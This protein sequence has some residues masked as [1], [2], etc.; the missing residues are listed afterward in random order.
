MAKVRDS[1]L[2]QI[3]GNGAVATPSVGDGRLIPYLLLDCQRRF[4]IHDLILNHQDQP[5]GDVMSSWA[6]ARFDSNSVFLHLD[7]KRPTP[8][9]FFIQFDLSKHAM[10]VDGLMQ[11]NVTYIQSNTVAK[12]VVDGGDKPKILIEIPSDKPP[13]V[14][15]TL[16]EKLV[17]KQFRRE[18]LKRAQAAEAAKMAIAVS[19]DFWALRKDHLQR[20]GDATGDQASSAESQQQSDL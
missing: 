16:F 14:W 13:F 7:F 8:A 5:P 15:D 10:L 18:G 6:I 17:R 3:A 4:D 11:S 9:N 1:E 20:T 2:I 12:D 19:R